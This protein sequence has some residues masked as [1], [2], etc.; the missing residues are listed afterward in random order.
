MITIYVYGCQTCG[1]KAQYIRKVQSYG[2]QN[3]V[4]VRVLNSKYDRLARQDHAHYLDQANLSLTDY[5]PIV[6]QDN[7]VR[8][9]LGWQP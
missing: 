8:R 6:V 2:L 5:Q 1:I 9:L 4:H 3:K 7:E